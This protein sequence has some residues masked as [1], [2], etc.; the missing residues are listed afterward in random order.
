MKR[1]NPTETPVRRRLTRAALLCA[2]LATGT[3]AH[4]AD[5]D[6]DNTK[7]NQGSENSLTPL[8]QKNNQADID[9]A[10]A[11]RSA[12]VGNDALSVN[13]KNIKIIANYGVVTLR[14]PV[15]SNAE[16]AQVESIVQSIAGV[17]RIDNQL[18]VKK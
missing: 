15:E 7:R 9:T 18:T 3:A 6:A 5:A 2:A 4:A 8:D 12:I 11:I 13:A 14:G 17:T 10:A 16:K 1:L